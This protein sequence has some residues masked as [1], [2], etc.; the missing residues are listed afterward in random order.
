MQKKSV[1]SAC[2]V[3]VLNRCRYRQLLIFNSSH[4]DPPLAA[5]ADEA[6]SSW[7]ECLQ[8]VEGVSLGCIY[9]MKIEH[10]EGALLFKTNVSL[11]HSMNTS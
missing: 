8:K 3:C 6:P 10:H 5:G 9:E 11:S 4:C 1:L 7:R 2:I